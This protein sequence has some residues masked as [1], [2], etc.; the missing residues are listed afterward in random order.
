MVVL[1]LLLPDTDIRAVLKA[2]NACVVTKEEHQCWH[3]R[4]VSQVG[5]VA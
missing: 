3:R 4:R 2:A 5:D 1:R